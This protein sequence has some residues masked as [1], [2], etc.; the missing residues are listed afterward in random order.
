M[1]CMTEDF[2]TKLLLAKGKPFAISSIIQDEAQMYLYF[3]SA[4]PPSSSSPHPPVTQEGKKQ[5]GRG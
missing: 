2:Q 4:A 5:R 3:C 1:T